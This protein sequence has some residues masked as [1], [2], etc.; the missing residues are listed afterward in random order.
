MYVCLFRD[1]YTYFVSEMK[2]GNIEPRAGI[3]PTS[4]ALQASVLPLH[5]VGSLMSAL[6]PC[7]PVYVAV[8]IRGQG[9]LL[10]SSLWNCKSSNAYNYIYT[11][12]Q[13][14][15]N[16]HTVHSLYRIMDT[17]TSVM[18]AMNLT[19]SHPFSGIPGQCATITLG[20]YYTH[21]HLLMGHLAS[22]VSADYYPNI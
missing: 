6:Y 9:R 7:P 3:E 10:H 18:G 5:Q 16:N 12:L 13:G 4:L 17:A 19:H 1:T 11:A 14:R 8:C 2:L 22:E 21:A 20:Q 15:I